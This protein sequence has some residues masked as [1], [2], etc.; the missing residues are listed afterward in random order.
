MDY[1]ISK[2][3]INVFGENKAF[4]TF[5]KVLTFGG[6]KWV[7][8]ALV[9][10][11]LIFKRTRK[12]G[13]CCLFSVAICFIL[14]DFVIKNIVQRQRPFVFDPALSKMCE[15]AN[16]K[17]PDGYSMASGHAAV[18]M[19]FAVAVMMNSWKFGIPAMI[20]S[21]VVGFSRV[22]LCVHYLTDVLAGFVLGTVVA[23]A[24]YF[25]ILLIKK[26]LMKRRKKNENIGDS[27]CEQTQA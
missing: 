14:N 12:I 13:I 18:T 10:V 5:M 9:L 6:S 26:F 16:L 2:W 4:A 17:F 3:V 11:L 7:L 23:V 8:I 21:L 15:L 22:F 1:Q 27:D 24:V 19:A 20:Y 25:S